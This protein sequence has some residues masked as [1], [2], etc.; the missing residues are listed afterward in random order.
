MDNPLLQ[1]SHIDAY[2]NEWATFQF[3]V[4]NQNASSGTQVSVG[5]LDIVY[6]WETTLGAA[7][8]F[9][10]ELNQGIAL[11]SGAQVAVPIAFSGGS[12]GAVM[13]SDLAIN[14]AS[15]YDSSISITGNPTGLYPNGDIIEV[16][17]I[18]SIDSST[19]AAFAEARLRMESSSGLVELSFSELSLFNEAYDPDN[20]VTME[21]SS[22]TE[23]GDEMHVTWRFRVNTAWEDTPELRIYA[24]LIADNGVNGLPGAVVLAPANEMLVENDALISAFELRNDAGDLQDLTA[25]TSNQNINL[26]GSIRLEGW[27]LLQIQQPQ[28]VST[29]LGRANCKRYSYQSGL[30][31]QTNLCRGD[32]DWDVDLVQQQ[33]VKQ[34]TAS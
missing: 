18:H 25:A 5:N 7:A 6:E 13:L 33:Q 32:F 12:G 29:A 30:K 19:N 23:V 26:M 14:T 10:R 34:H 27:M 16:K 22:Y 28:F 3:K 24:N 15:G 31:F 17:S 2:G 8:N 11:G 9:D 4:S 20:L 21:S 1:A